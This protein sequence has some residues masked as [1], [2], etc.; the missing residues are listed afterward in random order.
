M[1]KK[2]RKTTGKTSLTLSLTSQ[3]CE[4]LAEMSQKSGFSRSAFVESLLH[5]KVAITA[6]EAVKNIALTPSEGDTASAQVKIEVLDEVLAE[7]TK[8]IATVADSESDLVKELQAKIAEQNQQIAQ[9]ESLQTQITEQTK[10]IAELETQIAQNKPVLKQPVA[11]PQKLAIDTEKTKQEL[12]AKDT[13]IADLTQA[14]KD[15]EARL[16]ALGKQQTEQEKE[17]AKIVADLQ[18]ELAQKE[19]Q[20]KTEREQNATLENQLQEQ[21]N[22]VSSLAK[23]VAQQKIQDETLAQLEAQLAKAKEE[24]DRQQKQLSQAQEQQAELK[25]QLAAAESQQQTLKAQLQQVNT[26]KDNLNSELA[27]AQ[28]LVQELRQ[29]VGMIA[30]LQT[31]LNAKQQLIQSLQAQIAAQQQSVQAAQAQLTESKGRYAELESR[32]HALGDRLQVLE[33]QASQANTVTNI[34]EFYLNRWRK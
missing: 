12:V 10:K 3:A 27:K 2:K 21:Y 15:T 17:Q 16:E 6:P 25:T 20:V 4:Y 22:R 23:D 14:I 26:E 30:Q 32:Y 13:K 28:S 7:S 5:G 1:V 8:P 11:P 29:Q 18:K 24:G 33:T 34:G 19:A 9:A 31:E